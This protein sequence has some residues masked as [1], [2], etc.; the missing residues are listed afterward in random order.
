MS[1]Q[2][3]LP[4]ETRGFIVLT[5]LVQ[6]LLLWLAETGIEHGWWPFY[7]LGGR[8]CWYTLVLGIPGVMMLSVRRLDERRF[9]QHAALVGTAL[10]ALLAWAVWSATGAPGLQSSAVLG[11][12]GCTTALALFIALPWLQCRLQY[13]VW[14]APYADLFECAWQNAL[15]LLLMLAFVGVCW[16]VLTLW[17]SLFSLVKIDFFKNLFR[18]RAFIYLATGGMAGIGI[19]IGRTQQHPIR[20]ARQIVLAVFTG[21]LPLLAFIA[22]LFAVSLLFTGLAP[23]WSTRSATA[24]LMTL[25]ALI[26]AF[27]NAVYQ[28]GQRAPPYPS[29]LRLI[30]DAGLLVLPIHAVIGLYALVLR[31][32]QYG[33][34]ADRYWA[35]LASLILAAYAFGY[36]FAALRRGAHWLAPIRRVNVALALATIALIAA[37]NSPLLD[38]HR[39]SVNDQ[40]ARWDDGRTD[41]KHLDLEHLRF[42]SGRRGYQAVQ[43]LRTHP[44]MAADKLLSV[45]LEKI[46]QRQQRY[47]WRGAEEKL[48]DAV[49]ETKQFAATLRPA[50]N[51]PAPDEAFLH[52]LLNSDATKTECRQVDDDCVYIARDFD[53][54]GSVDALLC[55][56]SSSS[57]VSCQLWDRSSGSW[58]A[59]A[60]L[61][62]YGGDANAIRRALRTGEIDLVPKRWPGLKAGG[63]LATPAAE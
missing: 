23:L 10:A 12:Y 54:D 49:T 42:D 18:E 56:L 47:A 26:V 59:A 38:P 24:I 3:P 1:T 13:G 52:A 14:R 32:H 17:G 36:A 58:R 25:V 5:A 41:A 34:T 50:A 2:I 8:V 61:N 43:S 28:D 7:Q 46:I 40:L 62:W 57:F 60:R 53:G 29:W 11:P 20:I 9:W 22:L 35:S 44:R 19:L 21:L 27:T 37:S 33:W 31:I 6:G 39:L 4:R 63:F 45:E 16:G 51:S 15:T 48:R 30:I 55:H